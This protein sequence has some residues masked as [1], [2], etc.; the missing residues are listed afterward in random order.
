MRDD[1]DWHM[2]RSF[3]F[4]PRFFILQAKAPKPG[5]TRDCALS[6][7]GMSLRTFPFV[8]SHAVLRRTGRL[9]QSYPP[10]F[11]GELDAVLLTEALALR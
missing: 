11:I 1:S 10:F 6:Q 2:A 8:Q 4:N 9:P 5:V 7:S 3:C